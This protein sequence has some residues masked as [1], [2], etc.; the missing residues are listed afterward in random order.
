MVSIRS[1][2][3]ALTGTVLNFECDTLWRSQPLEM[4]PE[5]RSHMVPTVASEYDSRCSIHDGLADYVLDR[6]MSV[7]ACTV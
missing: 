3:C 7:C 4:I 6:I 5:Q 1:P 2:P